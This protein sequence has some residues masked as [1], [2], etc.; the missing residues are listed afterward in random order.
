MP[1]RHS[2]RRIAWPE[3]RCYCGWWT[4]L[5]KPEEWGRMKGND[6]LLDEHAVHVIRERIRARAK[7]QEEE[8]E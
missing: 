5:L 7:R 6:W 1:K 8:Q 4:R 2:I 3:I